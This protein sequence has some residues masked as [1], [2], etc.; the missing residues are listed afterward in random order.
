M[1]PNNVILNTYNSFIQILRESVNDI[2]LINNYHLKDYARDL[3][4]EIGNICRTPLSLFHCL[5]LVKAI[6]NKKSS[7]W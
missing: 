1:V 7:L 4:M 2:F 5:D 6:C 3:S